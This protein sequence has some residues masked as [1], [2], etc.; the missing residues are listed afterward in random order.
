VDGAVA[1][2]ARIHAARSRGFSLSKKIRAGANPA[3]QTIIGGID[4]ARRRGGEN[5]RR[6]SQLAR[7][8]VL[9]DYAAG[10]DQ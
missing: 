5:G 1:A 9:R 4:C 10:S 7:P 6:Q 3:S 8:T 2:G